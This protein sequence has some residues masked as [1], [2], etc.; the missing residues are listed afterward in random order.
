M[1]VKSGSGNALITYHLRICTLNGLV[2]QCV[3]PT[4]SYV[5]RLL[6]FYPYLS[7][8][9]DFLTFFTNNH[10]SHACALVLFSF[11][12]PKTVECFEILRCLYVNVT[13]EQSYVRKEFM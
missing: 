8:S 12:F 9:W 6:Y 3:C 5:L 11:C 2:G 10:R 1:M 4:A 13:P 7:Y